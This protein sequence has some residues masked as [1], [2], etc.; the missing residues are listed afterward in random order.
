MPAA[1]AVARSL[2][3]ALLSL[4][5]AARASESPEP[6]ADRTLSPY[7]FVEGGDSGIDRLPLL[8]TSVHIDIAGVIAHVTVK[9][10]YKND[11]TRPIHARYVFPASTKK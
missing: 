11:G 6:S 7:F 4:A 2:L 3:I 9:Q 1:R 5:P 10:S 8:G